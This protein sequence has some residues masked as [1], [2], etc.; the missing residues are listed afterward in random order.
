MVCA[1][2]KLTA[3]SASQKPNPTKNTPGESYL[4]DKNQARIAFVSATHEPVVASFPEGN[5]KTPP[6]PAHTSGGPKDEIRQREEEDAY[7]RVRCSGTNGTLETPNAG[8]EY[9]TQPALL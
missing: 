7:W 1:D 8:S 9:R 4:I 3:S 2:F 6:P 5:G